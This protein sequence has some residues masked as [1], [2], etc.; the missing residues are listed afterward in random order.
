M[1]KK[2]FVSQVLLI[3]PLIGAILGSV[4]GAVVIESE[5]NECANLV[6][7][8][9]DLL[10]EGDKKSVTYNLLKT[11]LSNKLAR[12]CGLHVVQPGETLSSIARLYETTIGELRRLNPEIKDARPPLVIAQVLKIREHNENHALHST[13]TSSVE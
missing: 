1:N 7:K 3:I 6:A 5:E 2:K 8:L 11:A 9:S 4:E 12:D 10:L 13:E